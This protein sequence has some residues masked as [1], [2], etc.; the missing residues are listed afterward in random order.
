MQEVMDGAMAA[1]RQRLSDPDFTGGLRV[2]LTR[3]SLRLQQV[4]PEN[5][6]L[7]ILGAAE[8]GLE[9]EVAALPKP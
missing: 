3:P 6:A 4:V 5:D 9:A 2:T 7:A 8:A 1:L